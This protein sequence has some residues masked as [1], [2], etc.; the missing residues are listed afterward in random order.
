[1]RKV[2]LLLVLA[3]AC[4]PFDPSLGD[5][6]FLCGTDDPQC[7]DGY[8]AVNVTSVRCECHL[9]AGGGGPNTGS[10]SNFNSDASEPNDSSATA[11]A[12]PIGAAN[13]AVFQ[14]ASICPSTDE[15]Y[16]QMQ[17]DRTGTTMMVQ[18]TYE[19][20]DKPTVD[21]LDPSGVSVSPT[22]TPGT[23][24][25]TALYTSRVSGKHYALVK[26]GT[27]LQSVNYSL[28]LSITPPH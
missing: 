13:T 24:S 3:A 17:I 16:Y 27:T 23:G 18:V 14:N 25:V 6:P 5:A 12:T 26:A 10:C 11:T 7:P 20:A 8:T 19:G 2:L 28:H 1:M 22:I 21:I 15:D 9:A 4:S